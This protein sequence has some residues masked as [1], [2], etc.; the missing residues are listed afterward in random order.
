M[1]PACLYYHVNCVCIDRAWWRL[2]VTSQWYGGPVWTYW[3]LQKS[4]FN[5]FY[6]LTTG[7]LFEDFL[8]GI[9]H[10]ITCQYIEEKFLLQ[11]EW[12]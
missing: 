4:N 1:L 11:L 10:T 2:C 7:N 5:L 3:Y 9:K 12:P 8:Y 6:K